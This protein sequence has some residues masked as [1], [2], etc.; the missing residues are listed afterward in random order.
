MSEKAKMR[1]IFY[2]VV[3]L[4]IALI[5]SLIIGISFFLSLRLTGADSTPERYRFTSGMPEGKKNQVTLK[6]EDIMRNGQLCVNF[7]DIADKCSF[8][9]VSDGSE[10][11]FYLNNSHGDILTLK[12]SSSVAYLNSVPVRLS[13][14]VYKINGKV[15]LPLDFVGHYINGITVKADS[16][17]A[18]VNIE[19]SGAEKCFLNIKYPQPTM[20]IDGEN[21]QD[22]K[23]ISP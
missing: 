8:T 18:T 20:P 13:T 15:Y 4:S 19:Y 12:S 10:M 1:F 22:P 5:I 2:T 23:P 3:S 11:R 21:W 16:E 7:S 14:E 6:T 17:N 9:F